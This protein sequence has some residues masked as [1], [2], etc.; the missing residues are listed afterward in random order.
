MKKIL[1]ILVLTAFAG[2]VM[3]ARAAHASDWDKAGIALT[4]I[5]GLRILSGGK[6]D[7]VG[8]IFGIDNAA[9]ASQRLVKHDGRYPRRDV[10]MVK[11]Q[12]C[13]KQ[14]WVPHYEWKRKFVPRHEEYHEK[15]G[16]II[17]EAHYIQYQ[18]E[19]GGHW[20]THDY[21]H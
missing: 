17:V 10:K 3:P 4:G 16:Q 6:I 15:Y 13:V 7:I 8:K 5:E 20:D 14:V 18:I 21:C 11:R 19:A 1:V 12:S 9:S 2:G